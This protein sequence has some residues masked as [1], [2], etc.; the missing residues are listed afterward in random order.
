MLLHDRKERWGKEAEKK[1]R[2]VQGKKKTIKVLTVPA[3]VLWGSQCP[4][5][6]ALCP[7]SCRLTLDVSWEAQGLLGRLLADASLLRS[8]RSVSRAPLYPQAA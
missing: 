2:N 6:T 4:P 7:G 3:S 8:G 5:R 1:E